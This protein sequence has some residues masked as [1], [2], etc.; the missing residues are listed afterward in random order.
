M[1]CPTCGTHNVVTINLTVAERRVTMR[2]CGR[3]DKR[4]WASDGEHIDL[5]NVLELAA[6]RR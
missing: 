1:I 6:A 5:T 4:W 3:C 2:S